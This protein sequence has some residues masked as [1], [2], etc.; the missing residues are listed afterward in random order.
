M[1]FLKLTRSAKGIASRSGWLLAE[2]VFVF[3][4]LYGAFVLERMHDQD[5][6]LLRKRQILDALVGEFRSYTDELSQASVGLDEGYAQPFFQ[7]YAGGAMPFPKPIPYGGIAS[8]N[9]GIW[10]ALLQSGIEVLEIDM[11]QRI[12]TFFKNLQDF[13]DLFSRFEAL[14]TTYILPDYEQN[15]TFFYESDSPE[16]RD[17]YKWYANQLFDL[18]TNLRALS[19]EAAATQII[20]VEKLR[21]TILEENPDAIFDENGTYLPGNE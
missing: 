17:K 1:L 18:G 7:E 13:L 20:L 2:L 10:E 12:Q 19:E 4:G 6:D 14:C 3:L 8:V 5:M 16:L 21:E 15:A 9:T 11:I